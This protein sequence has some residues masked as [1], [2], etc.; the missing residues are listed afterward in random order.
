M[1]SGFRMPAE[2]EPHLATWM[3]FPT[4]NFTFGPS[5]SDSLERY[6]RAWA[7]V[8]NAIAVFEPVLMVC[9]PNDVFAAQDL[10]GE[11]VELLV[12]IIDDAW[13]RDSGPTFV[14]DDRGR[15]GAVD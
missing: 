15:L 14:M 3:Q 11:G 7:D 10:L 13:C 8:A 6:Q 12:D 5:G 1:S 2:W 9:H 4:G